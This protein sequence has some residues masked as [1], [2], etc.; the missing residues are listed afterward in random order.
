M[1]R[2]L[3]GKSAWCTDMMGGGLDLQNLHSIW[4]GVVAHCSLSV[5]EAETRNSGSKLASQSN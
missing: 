5:W 3:S 1:G 4:M 2:W